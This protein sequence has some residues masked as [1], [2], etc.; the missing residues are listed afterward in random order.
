M[1]LKF[2]ELAGEINGSM[3]K[4]V[5]H[6]ISNY[7]NKI[8][9]SVNNSEILILGMSYK[10]NIDDLRESPSLKIADLLVNL[11]AKVSFSDPYF[12]EL[13]KLRKYDFKI[14]NIKLNSENLKK[15]D[16]T[17]LATDHDDFDYQLIE[18]NSNFIIDTRGK[19]KIKKN[20]VRG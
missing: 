5:I 18:E 9:R 8:S 7:F 2:I 20:I 6:K 17:V 1:N 13:P 14:K 11:G 15:F 4:Y 10:K 19:F 16:C 3:P 12:K